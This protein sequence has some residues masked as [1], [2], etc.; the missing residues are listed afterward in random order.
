MRH[1]NATLHIRCIEMNEDLKVLFHKLADLSPG[2][3]EAFYRQRHVPAAARAELES[4]LIF[5][6][7]GDDSL[8][9]LVDPPRNSFYCPMLPFQKTGG[10]APIAWCNYSVTAEW[11]RFTSPSG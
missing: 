7:T 11:A 9:G 1:N 5:D 3:R 6:E 10:V 8:T 2:Q 4:L